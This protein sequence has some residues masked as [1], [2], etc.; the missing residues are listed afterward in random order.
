MS[1]V[2]IKV[3]KRMTMYRLTVSEINCA[4]GLLMEQTR[5]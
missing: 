1:M 3:N 5:Q 2:I 4:N